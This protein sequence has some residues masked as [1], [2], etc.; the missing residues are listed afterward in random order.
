MMTPIIE[1]EG[2][3]RHGQRST[4]AAKYFE[5]AKTRRIDPKTTKRPPVRRTGF[6]LPPSY[7]DCQAILT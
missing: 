6:F 3:L 2:D 5:L 4:E 7:D 1:M